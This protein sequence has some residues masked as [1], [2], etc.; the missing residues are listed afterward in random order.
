MHIRTILP[1][2][3]GFLFI[4]STSLA[5]QE[6]RKFKVTHWDSRTGM[7][8]DISLNIY[9]TNDGFI[10]LTGYSGLIRFDGVQF[11]IFNSRTDSIF[12]SDVISS[13]IT[14]TPD[15]AL[16]I[17]TPG[18]GFIRYK[19]GRFRSFLQ[20]KTTSPSLE[21]MTKMNS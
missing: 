2:L 18:S 1:A 8:N 19:N 7:P 3:L 5:Q 15:S 4:H 9:Q 13:I 11:T 16:W 20:D 17:P 14:Q 10:W 21:T 6:F 12:K